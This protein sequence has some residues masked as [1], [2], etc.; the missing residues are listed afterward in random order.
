ML[1]HHIATASPPLNQLLFIG[2]VIPKGRCMLRGATF[3]VR[4]FFFVFNLWLERQYCTVAVSPHRFLIS[5]YWI[6]LVWF[7]V[8][9]SRI[10]EAYGS[11]IRL[12]WLYVPELRFLESHSHISEATTLGLNSLLGFNL[13]IS[14]HGRRWQNYRYMPRHKINWIDCR[15]TVHDERIIILM[16]VLPRDRHKMNH[17][18]IRLYTSKK[19]PIGQGTT[20]RLWYSFAIS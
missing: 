10:V 19:I 2:T 18:P 13:P 9:E 17:S 11:R 1:C 20:E 5:G 6:W 15:R 12:T 4:N 8:P 3:E 14:Q 16:T 7:H